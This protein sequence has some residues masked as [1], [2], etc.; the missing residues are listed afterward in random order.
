MTAIVTML[1][2]APILRLLSHSTHIFRYFSRRE[3]MMWS[4]GVILSMFLISVVSG[5]C[6]GQHTLQST[7]I[8]VVINGSSVIVNAIDPV[9]KE[10]LEDYF[11]LNISLTHIL[12][13][14]RTC[15]ETGYCYC[16]WGTDPTDASLQTLA[17]DDF[18]CS[19]SFA[20][21][22]P[23][24]GITLSE[25]RINFT[26]ADYPNFYVLNTWYS[27]S[28][29]FSIQ[30]SSNRTFV[31]PS[32]NYTWFYEYVPLSRKLAVTEFEMRFKKCEILHFKKQQHGLEFP[33]KNVGYGKEI[34]TEAVLDL[35]SLT[36]KSHLEIPKRLLTH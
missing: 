14:P 22:T 32:K 17:M 26:R 9:T 10:V 11:T 2:F 20:T 29:P 3:V 35:K 28:H 18:D 25:V 23:Q 13:K 21:T 1:S 34:F 7:S 12:E 36:F 15:N 5:T 33:L 30:P 6:S 8:E 4:V 19:I 31:H 27:T 16:D 24:P